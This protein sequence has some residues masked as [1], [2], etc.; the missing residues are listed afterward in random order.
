M[1]D[2]SHIAGL[3]AGGVYPSPVEYADIVTT[4]THKT[5]RG[6]RGAMIMVTEKG[7]KFDPELRNKISKSVFPGMQGGPHLNNIAA[8]GVCLKEASS[9]SF[10][11]YVKQIILN[12]KA[13]ALELKKLGY[14]LIGDVESHLIL[15]D[16]GNMNIDGQ[17]AALALEEAGIIVNKNK[18]PGDTGSAL[19]PSG[20]RLGTPFLTSRGMKEKEMKE[21]ALIIDEVIKNVS[22]KKT[23]KR[24][25][26]KTLKL[27]K[28]F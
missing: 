12:T 23:L 11:K 1:A 16:L 15:I 9:L 6:P 24:L 20:I 7:L 19:K 14:T 28:R 4:T 17:T 3:I 18:I 21:I 10:K 25:K 2:I 27:S 26:T 5:L 22:D 8:M 13:L